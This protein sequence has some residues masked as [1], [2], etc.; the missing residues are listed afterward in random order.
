[1]CAPFFFSKKKNLGRFFLIFHIFFGFSYLLR[2]AVSARCLEKEMR[3][4]GRDAV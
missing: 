2:A 1:V 4:V 3:P